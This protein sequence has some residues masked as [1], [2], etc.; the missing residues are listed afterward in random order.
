MGRIVFD[1]NY[2]VKRKAFECMPLTTRKDNFYTSLTLGWKILLNIHILTNGHPV[3]QWSKAL[4]RK[5]EKLHSNYVVAPPDKAANDVIIIWKRYYVDILKE[6]FISTSK[7]AP[8]QLTKDKLL[9]HHTDTLMNIY[10]K[11]DKLNCLHFIGYQ[12][13][14]NILK[15]HP[16]YLILVTT[17]L[18]FFLSILHL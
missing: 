15:N 12:S 6:E 4:N 2:G 9:L 5:M 14:T 18:P 16:L 1:I 10:V 3:D 8:A 13:F 7:Y 17:L 11:I